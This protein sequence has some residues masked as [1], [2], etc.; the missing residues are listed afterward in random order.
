LEHAVKHQCHFD[1]NEAA[2]REAALIWKMIG[3]LDR[4]VQLLNADIVD[5]ELR[6]RIFDR[7]DLAYPTLARSLGERRDNLLDTIAALRERLPKLDPI[8]LLDKV[9]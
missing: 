4:S 5:E 2:K 1:T 6:V 7:S 3:E 9:A 8:E